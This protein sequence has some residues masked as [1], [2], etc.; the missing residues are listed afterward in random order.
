MLITDASAAW[1]A[2][3][4][5]LSAVSRMNYKGEINR[6][7][8][9][10]A[11]SFGLL[12]VGELRADHWQKYLL[13]MRKKRKQIA[14]RR[15]DVLKA[16]SAIQAMR[17]TRQFLIWCAS[18]RLI[19]W[20]PPRIQIPAEDVKAQESSIKFP[21]AV[22]LALTG[23]ASIDAPEDARAV[24]AI[25]LAY[26]GALPLSDL[27]LL[28]LTDLVLTPDPVL[29]FAKDGRK[30]HLPTHL[31]KLWKRYRSLRE[32][33]GNIELH[34]TSPLIS[35]LGA[36]APVRPWSIWSMIK[37]WQNRNQVSQYL[38]PRMLRAG[39]VGSALSAEGSDLAATV[40]HAGNTLCRVKA[41]TDD[42]SLRIRRIQRKEM[43]RL[44]ATGGLPLRPA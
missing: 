9:Y 15:S 29:L 34:E 39:F 12:K 36:E 17:I 33:G 30:I 19:A 3:H 20:W 44:T 16:S 22:C 42:I 41:A 27:A 21:Q 35:R 5:A 23:G 37:D 7:G 14:N 13:S 25:N 18:N 4:S 11:A 24:L 32:D 40:A 26:W 1:L 38:S 2:A 10:A 43:L 28:K 6:F 31:R 8:Q